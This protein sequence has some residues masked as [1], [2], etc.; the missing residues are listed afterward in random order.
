MEVEILCVCRVVAP[1]EVG[2]IWRRVPF[3]G[4]DES[5]VVASWIGGGLLD[6]IDS[7][8]L[9][10]HGLDGMVGVTEFGAVKE[11]FTANG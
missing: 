3:G 6:M 9:D 4:E 8:V 2:L 1:A 7:E 5:H 11:R 10:G